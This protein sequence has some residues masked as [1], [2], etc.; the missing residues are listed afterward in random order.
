MKRDMDLVRSILLDIEEND[1]FCEEM[2]L[3]KIPPYSLEE[4]A[5]HV[6][7]MQDAELIHANVQW[8][9]PAPW[10]YLHRMAWKGHEF[11]D[12]ARKE[13]VWNQ[14]K[15]MAHKATGGVGFEAVTEALFALMRQ[16]LE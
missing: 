9:R 14:A 8:V 2:Y 16:A 5:Y 10:I 3:P 11:L 1:I 15:E 4:I 13:S 6:E 12:A 7:I